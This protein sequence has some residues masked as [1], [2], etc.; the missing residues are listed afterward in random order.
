MAQAK[1]VAFKKKV[2]QILHDSFVST[3]SEKLLNHHSFKTSR[4]LLRD[5]YMLQALY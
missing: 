4:N 1:K 3:L 2:F 5:C